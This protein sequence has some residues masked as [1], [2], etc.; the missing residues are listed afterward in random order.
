MAALTAEQIFGAPDLKME[1]ME[2]PEWDGSINIRV[3][4]GK[5]RDIIVEEAQRSLKSGK[6]DKVKA[7]VIHF[8]V[9]DDEGKPVFSL[10][11]VPALMDK[12]GVVIDRII[13]KAMEINGLDEKSEKDAEEN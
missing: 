13:A 10:D 12:N 5:Q 2:V 6:E 8:A 3:V 7:K 11:Q 9:C 4:S 1:P